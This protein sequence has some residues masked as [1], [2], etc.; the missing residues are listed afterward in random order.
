[1]QN[2]LEEV[3]TLAIA[4]KVAKESLIFKNMK[5]IFSLILISICSLAFSGC[6]YDKDEQLYPNDPSHAKTADCEAQLTYSSG[7]QT[8]ISEN[9]AYSGCHVSGSI[10][11]NLS[12]YDLVKSNKNKIVDRAITKKDMPKPTGMS[13]CNITKLKNWIDAGLPQ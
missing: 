3:V 10:S 7:I 2:I 1:M 5:K 11:P 13:S 4:K 8:L 9:C 6:Y 12:T